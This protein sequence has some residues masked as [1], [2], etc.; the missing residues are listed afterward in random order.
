MGR[1]LHAT[2]LRGLF[3]AFVDNKSVRIS[4]RNKQAVGIAQNN[5]GFNGRTLP[6]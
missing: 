2:A 6:R 5:D 4:P 1:G 3:A